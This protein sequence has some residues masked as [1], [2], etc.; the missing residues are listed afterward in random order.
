VTHFVGI[1]EKEPGTLWSIWFPDCPGCTTA[2]DD[3]E[4]AVAQAPE[5]LKL[6]LEA[7]VEDGEALPRPRTIDD[8]K[9]DATVAA[10]FAQGH[11]AIMVPAIAEGGRSVRANISMDAGLLQAVDK[12]AKARG[13]TRSAFL[14]S[15]ARDKILAEV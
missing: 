14:A 3:I 9:A 4:K 6:W 1:L 8:L 5:A 10:A 13:L 2:S 11:V 12:A 15:A 7:T